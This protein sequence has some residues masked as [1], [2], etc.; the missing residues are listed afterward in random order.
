MDG[1]AYEPI[2]ATISLGSHTVLEFSKT[3]GLVHSSLLLQR[4]SCV[5]LTGPAYEEYLHG[6][7]EREE[8][9]VDGSHDGGWLGAGEDLMIKKRGTRWSLTFRRVKSTSRFRLS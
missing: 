2:V 4:R 1:P 3:P 5:V 8:D 6:I 7:S 9:L